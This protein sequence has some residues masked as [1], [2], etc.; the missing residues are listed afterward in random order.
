[1]E[2]LLSSVLANLILTDVETSIIEKLKKMS[3]YKRYV[4]DIVLTI[5]R[6]D[7][8]HIYQEFNNVHPRIQFTIEKETINKIIFLDLTILRTMK[9]SYT[10]IG[11]PNQ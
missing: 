3:F 7:I 9:K 5:N 4:D 10:L 1:M 6:S 11:A 8:N 2:N